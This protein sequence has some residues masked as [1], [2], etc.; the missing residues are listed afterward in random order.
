M[1]QL[2][3]NLP[4]A[5]MPLCH[6]RV[7]GHSMEPTLQEGDLVLVNRW[8]YLFSTPK[9]G[10]IIVA[11]DPIKPPRLILKRIKERQDKKLLV[12]GDNLHCK[13]YRIKESQILGRVIT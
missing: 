1:K 5:V 6:F 2:L 3:T 11:Q 10:D 4:F 13:A 7:F 12:A 9:I 8:A